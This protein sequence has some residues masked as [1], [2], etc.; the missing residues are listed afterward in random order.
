MF[1]HPRKLIPIAVISIGIGASA[2]WY[3]SVDASGNTIA[4]GE[5]KSS[6][7]TTEQLAAEKH[8]SS[9]SNKNNIELSQSGEETSK[10]KSPETNTASNE[11]I[12]D[13]KK[14]ESVKEAKR[15]S[16]VV[17]KHVRTQKTTMVKLES[18]IKGFEDEWKRIRTILK[19]E[20]SDDRF[21]STLQKADTKA[22]YL[23]SSYLVA[24][25]QCYH[26]LRQ[27]EELATSTSASEN[28]IYT[29]NK[30]NHLF[31]EHIEM[32]DDFSNSY[33]EYNLYLL[34]IANLYENTMHSISQ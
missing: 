9:K 30:F 11:V 32:G 5:T 27:M 15:I 17:I 28:P 2:G 3:L 29:I 1:L 6:N 26:N 34:H 12:I 24:K 31:Q 20:I 7:P 14:Q 18:G 4:V 19:K 25:G 8:Q 33:K 22:R 23:K 21:A 13:S 16:Q 10:T